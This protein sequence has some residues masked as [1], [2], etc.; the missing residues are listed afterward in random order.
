MQGLIPFLIIFY[1]ILLGVELTIPEHWEKFVKYCIH[2]KNVRYLGMLPLSLGFIVLYSVYKYSFTVTWLLYILS[3]IYLSFGAMLLL[4]PQAIV[5]FYED[6]YFKR[7][8]E[9]KKRVLKS[10]IIIMTVILSLLFIA[11]L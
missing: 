5:A 10:D 4:N 3:L 9:E 8:D 2:I 7:T 1:L 11:L 6:Y